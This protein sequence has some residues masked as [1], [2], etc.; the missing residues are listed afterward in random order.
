MNSKTT[1]TPTRLSTLTERENGVSLK[2]RPAGRVPGVSES[3][4]N[5]DLYEL[6]IFPISQDT[7]TLRSFFSGHLYPLL[8]IMAM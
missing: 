3:D 1:L 4:I 6:V 5:L 8:R 7:V 2:L